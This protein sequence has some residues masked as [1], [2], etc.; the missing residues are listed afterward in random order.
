MYTYIKHICVCWRS[1]VKP[2]QDKDDCKYVFTHT[3]LY[4]HIR[5]KVCVTYIYIYSVCVFD[6][7]TW[8]NQCRKITRFFC[9]TRKTVSSNS[10]I[11]EKI[12]NPTHSPTGPSKYQSCKQSHHAIWL[13]RSASHKCVAVCCSVSTYYPTNTQFDWVVVRRTSVLQCVAVLQP[14]TLQTH[15][16][17]NPGHSHVAQYDSV[18]VRCS[19]L[20]CVAARCS[21]L[22]CV[23]VRCSALQCVAVR[24]S[25]LQCAAVCCS[26]L[27]CV[28]VRCSALRHITPQ[29][30]SSYYS[31][32]KSHHTIWLSY[33]VLQCIAVG[34]NMLQPITLPAHSSYQ[35]CTMKTPLYIITCVYIH[36]CIHIYM[37][38]FTYTCIYVHVCTWMSSFK[39]LILHH[40]NPSVYNHMCIYTF[41][42][43]H[44]HVSTFL[45]ALEW[46]HSSCQSCTYENPSVHRHV[47]V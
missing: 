6:T 31:Y 30:Y 8:W 10:G 20:Q 45:Y 41:M 40:E 26:A 33:S 17:A 46:A 23:A 44:T 35:S 37:C 22:Q 34:Y 3:H 12:N 11:L 14:I 4:L 2:I 16:N 5:V 28:A 47:C 18:A 7:V 29:A 19:A 24:C 32:A 39:I 25:A 13:S 15:P 43:S 42:Y 36:V 21:A 1:R 9:N 27:Q 38:V